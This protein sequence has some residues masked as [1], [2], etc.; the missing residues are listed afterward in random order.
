MKKTIRIDLLKPS[1]FSESIYLSNPTPDLVESIKQNGVLV[2]IWIDK[3]NTIIAGHRRV[4]ACIKLG[5][6]EIPAEVKE[7]SDSLVIE[8]NRYREKTW[9]EKLREAEALERI[10]RPR[11]K[12]QQIRKPNSVSANLQKQPIDTGK[13]ISQVLNVG[14]RTLYKVKAIA[15][16]RP[17]LIKDI[18]LGKKSVNSA[19]YIVKREE[20][21]KEFHKK[22]VSL[23]EGKFN[24]IYADPPWQH[25]PNVESR[26]VENHYPTLTIDEICNYKIKTINQFKMCL[27]ITLC[28]FYGLHHLN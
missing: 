17:E 1:E 4:N 18:D 3:D 11:A 13:E 28:C 27:Q 8:S 25:N 26:A 14:E 5:I 9:A 12:E 20:N 16:E 10:L 6:Q 21:L 22:E 7:Y 23:P 15:K 2:P 24:V 19:Y